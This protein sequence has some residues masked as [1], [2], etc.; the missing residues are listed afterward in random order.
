MRPWS[1][2]EDCGIRISFL[3]QRPDHSRSWTQTVANEWKET[4]SHCYKPVWPVEVDQ[5]PEDRCWIQPLDH[6]YVFISWFSCWGLPLLYSLRIWLCFSFG[7]PG[8]RLCE[9]YFLLS[10]EGLT[11][12]C[13]IVWRSRS[14]PPWCLVRPESI[15]GL[16]FVLLLAGLTVIRSLFLR[17][18]APRFLWS[19]SPPGFTEQSSVGTCCLWRS[20]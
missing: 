6:V 7:V 16:V 15:H 19:L 20:R 10:F 12:S 2:I 18:I 9:L 3:E 4:R 1:N 17:F 8:S 11:L 14:S 13:W 5:C